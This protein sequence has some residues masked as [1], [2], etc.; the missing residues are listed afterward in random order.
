MH[1]HDKSI[2]SGLVLLGAILWGTTGTSQALAP[3][4]ASPL[5][6]G[7]VRVTIGGTALLLLAFLRGSFANNQPW[8]KKPTFFAALS[9]AAYQPFFFAGVSKT[10]V[11]IG[12]VVTIG[13]SPI[14]A[15]LLA[16][17]L[18]K[19][20]PGQRW[21]AATLLAII[22]C[23]LLFATDNLVSISISGIV[24][25]LCAG[26]SYASYA[27]LSKQIL[28]HHPPEAVIAVIFCIGS[29]ILSP[30]LFTQKLNWLISSRGLAVALYLGI[31]TAAAAYVLF[32]KGLAKI[33]AAN[34]VTLSLA[35]PLTAAIL[36]ITFLG[37]TLSFSALGGIALLFSG[38][39][40]MTLDKK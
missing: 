13:S 3:E 24:M 36:G 12:T 4:G 14:F 8:L 9:M 10:G 19:E 22:G 38:L 29:I 11:A 39:L 30:L 35:E 28:E 34:A 40:I 16:F 31:V 20:R 6:I 17:L 5:A 27:L 33:P 15:G 7:A 25:A 32:S 21:V 37:E 23:I 26:F 2:G 1:I 18:F